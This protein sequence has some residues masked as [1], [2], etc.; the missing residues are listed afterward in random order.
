MEH[1]SLDLAW[2]LHDVGYDKADSECLIMPFETFTIEVSDG[3][4]TFEERC[5]YTKV[6]QD[7]SDYIE[8][9]MYI[10]KI[11]CVLEWF[12]DEKDIYCLPYF[13][14]EK[15]NWFFCILSVD[16][17]LFKSESIYQSYEDAAKAGIEYVIDLGLCNNN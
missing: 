1:V 4:I 15:K 7:I 2:K 13:D 12:R 17:D 8:K 9:F 10:P 16:A 5:I 11:D 6:F 14:L 3:V